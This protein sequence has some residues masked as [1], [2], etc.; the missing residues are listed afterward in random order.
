MSTGKAGIGNYVSR[1]LNTIQNGTTKIKK[2]HV[3][4]SHPKI[5]YK[6]KF[7]DEYKKYFECWKKKLEEEFEGVY[8]EGVF[9]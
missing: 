9:Y 5:R 2:V 3:I 4:L 1:Y 6:K 8:Q 7:D